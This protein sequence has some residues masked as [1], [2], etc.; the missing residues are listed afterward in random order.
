M[1]I[2]F[3][4]DEKGNEVATISKADF[5]KALAEAKANAANEAKS[6]AIEGVEKKYNI[7][8]EEIRN[9]QRE[10]KNLRHERN[11]DAIKQEYLA[12]GGK[13]E[14][15][16]DFYANNKFEGTE[17]LKEDMKKIKESKNIFFNKTST[18]SSVNFPNEMGIDT[19]TPADQIINDGKGKTLS[20]RI[21]EGH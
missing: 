8:F 20:Q 2:D 3:K 1:S 7:S 9:L 21:R 4:K 14:Y 19:D 15:F 18:M 17:N 6:N 5:D 16:N 11:V 10:V 12:Q 13:A